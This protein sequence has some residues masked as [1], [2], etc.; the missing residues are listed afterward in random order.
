[1]PKDS[2]YRP[3]MSPKEYFDL[4]CEREAGEFI[5]TNAEDVQGLL[6]MR[7]PRRPTDNDLMDRYKL[8]AP[9]IERTFQLVQPTAQERGKIFVNPPWRLYTFVEEPLDPPDS[10][11]AFARVSGYQQKKSAMMIERLPRADSRYGLTW[12]GIRRVHDRESTIA[13]SEWIVIDRSTDAPMAVL[14]DYV[15]TG[16]T[17]GASEGIWWLNAVNCPNSSTRNIRSNRIYDFSARVLKPRIG[18]L[19]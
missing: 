12:R 8:E 2:G 18:E 5:F 1:V 19:K 14:R 17:R 3:G 15:R 9:D 10:M 13:G 6:F 16:H 11:S 4:L 7:P